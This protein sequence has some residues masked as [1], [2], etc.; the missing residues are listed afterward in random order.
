MV[1]RHSLA[2]LKSV[3]AFSHSGY[4][5]AQLQGNDQQIQ[6]SFQIQLNPSIQHSVTEHLSQHYLQLHLRL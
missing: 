3:Q 6:E 1:P 2:L 4:E 5:E